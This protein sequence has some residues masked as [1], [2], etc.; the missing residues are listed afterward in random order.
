M[1]FCLASIL[2]LA[3]TAS[4]FAPASK[5]S[6]QTSL[7]STS[8]RGEFMK[9]IAT[10]FV[11][12]GGLSTLA[13]EAANAGWATGPGSGVIDPK[14]SIVDDEI[15]KTAP[16]QKSLKAVKGYASA[17]T[18]MKKAL[19]GNS[20]VDLKPVIRKEF[21]FSA[22]RADMNTLNT[23]FDEDT[24]RGTD[25]LIRVVLQDLNELEVA[26]AQKEGIPRSD[27]RVA[28]M[29]GKLN[30]LQD[31]FDTFL[32]FSPSAVE[33]KAPPAPEPEPAP[34]TEAV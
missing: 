26:N 30:K 15:F 18:E 21:E 1:K 27:I 2:S 28:K 5:Q 22:V 10:S 24:Q 19:S 17:V 25:R 13:P 7:Q 8:S 4:A 20:Q 6:V 32:K 11:V 34:T 23:A 3:A 9:Q 16:V 12:V 29:D 33:I 31:A 14:E